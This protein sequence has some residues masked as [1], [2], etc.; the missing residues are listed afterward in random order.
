[1]RKMTGLWKVKSFGF[2][3]AFSCV[4]G[5]LN[6]AASKLRAY[7]ENLKMLVLSRRKG[8]SVIID[9]DIEVVIADIRGNKVRLGINAAKQ[10][11]VYRKELLRR[12]HI[13]GENNKYVS[14]IE[15][16]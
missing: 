5:P 9:D 12:K 14:T 3:N 1:M 13:E 8:E 2:P 10:V 6:M 11:S 16:Q 4:C 7:R 15:P